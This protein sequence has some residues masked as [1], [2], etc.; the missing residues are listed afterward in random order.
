[1]IVNDKKLKKKKLKR[2]IKEM[3][4]KKIIN[5]KRKKKLKKNIKNWKKL[6][7]YNHNKFIEIIAKKRF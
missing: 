1:M 7:I 6:Q 5:L 4:N 3:K 2:M